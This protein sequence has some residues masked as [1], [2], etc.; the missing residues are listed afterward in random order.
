[1]RELEKYVAPV[2]PEL[3]ASGCIINGFTPQND[4]HYQSIVEA[5]R[6]F[7]VDIVVVLDSDMIAAKLKKMIPEMQERII[8]L[9]KS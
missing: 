8:E 3:F 4:R 5:I 9:Q 2:Y 1:M 7:K 6:Q